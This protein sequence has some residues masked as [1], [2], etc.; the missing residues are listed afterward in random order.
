MPSAISC[1]YLSKGELPSTYH[2]TDYNA[3]YLQNSF[4]LQNWM[5]FIINEPTSSQ[6]FDRYSICYILLSSF[7][8]NN[9]LQDFESL[10]TKKRLVSL[11]E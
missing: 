11:Y 2:L 7:P 10:Q 5:N 6:N 4:R 8:N 9:A 3:E 1:Q